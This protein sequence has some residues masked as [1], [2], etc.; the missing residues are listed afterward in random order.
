MI[1]KDKDPSLSCYHYF[2]EGIAIMRG[3]MKKTVQILCCG[4]L[5]FSSAVSVFAFGP[6]GHGTKAPGS[7]TA[8]A[9]KKPD[10][11]AMAAGLPLALPL[12][13]ETTLALVNGQPITMQELSEQLVALHAEQGAESGTMREHYRTLLDRLIVTRLMVAE[14]ENIGLDK[15]PEIQKE[16]ETFKATTLREELQREHLKDLL[17]DEEKVDSLYKQVSQ[18]AKLTT[19][20]FKKKEDA[21]KF[22]DGLKGGS[23]F[24]KLAKKF[25]KDGKAKIEA[26]ASY[27]KLKDLMPDLARAAFALEPGAV[28]QIFKPAGDFFLFKLEDKRFVEDPAAREEARL[29]VYNQQRLDKSLEYAEILKKKYVIFNEDA[30][31]ALDFEK[32]EVAGSGGN[33]LAAFEKLLK[34]QRV[35][36]TIQTEKPITITVSEIARELKAR[37]FHGVD[38]A[39]KAELNEKKNI[40]LENALFKICARLEAEKLGMDKTPSYLNRVQNHRNSLLFGMLIKKAIVP[41]VKISE[42]DERKYYSGHTADYLSPAMFKMKSL[43]YKTKQEAQA[44]LD[45][46]RKGSDFKWVSANSA[47]QV[48]K[49]A[50][51]KLI[52]EDHL[53]S[54]TSLPPA[55]QESVKG[56]RQGEF[57]LY[58]DPGKF[59]Y[60]LL[61]EEAHPATPQPFEQ[62][63]GEISKIVFNQKIKQAVDDYVRKLKEVYE[64]KVLVTDI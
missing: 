37:F 22:L 5:L 34:D 52:F 15:T 12:P 51:G 38:K 48:D 32:N 53:L 28:S 61:I 29:K 41:D 10:S 27:L 50:E 4:A 58:S 8:G 21:N 13:P 17:P 11:Q 36:A 54:I 7:E 55:L 39:E 57:I 49:E 31:A 40:V 56:A 46:L 3:A 62:V 1:V 35:L 23:S 47:G 59:A 45:K 18:E 2:E 25:V 20:S 24:D 44:A 33:A 16:M 42:E 64:T 6:A 19:I 26:D 9:Q 43:A 30:L 14:A 60:V 63:K